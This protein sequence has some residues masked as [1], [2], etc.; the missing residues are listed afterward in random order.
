LFEKRKDKNMTGNKTT[1]SQTGVLEGKSILIER[2]FDAPRE[3]VWKFWTEPEQMMR[4][5]GPKSFTAPYCKM[6]LRVGGKYLYCM[7]TPEGQDIWGT[8]IFREIVKPE[9]LVFT[10]SFADEKGNVVP[11]STYMDLDYPLELLVTVTFEEYEKGKTKLTLRHAGFPANHNPELEG[12]GW[13]ES[14]DKLAKILK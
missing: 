13:N 10:D 6:D 12:V 9:R 4:W 3:L 14:F 7:R 8:G 11:A 5:W 2:I 1:P